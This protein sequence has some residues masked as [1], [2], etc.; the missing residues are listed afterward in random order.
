MLSVSSGFRRK[1]PNFH[2][3]FRSHF[4]CTSQISRNMA[5]RWF[6]RCC[7]ACST[8]VNLS[9]KRRSI[10]NTTRQMRKSDE[11]PARFLISG[12]RRKKSIATKFGKFAVN[13]NYLVLAY[14][15]LCIYSE[16]HDAH[17][18]VFFIGIASQLATSPFFNI[19][20]PDL[21]YT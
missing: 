10:G 16:F 7:A 18:I 4:K 17:S 6:L 3:H 15:T 20:P 8:A 21:W 19:P 5:P 1:H 13:T 12:T 2:S 14:C 9:L 11:P